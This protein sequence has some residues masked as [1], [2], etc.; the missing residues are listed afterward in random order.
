MSEHEHFSAPE[1]HEHLDEEVVVLLKPEAIEFEDRLIAF[2]TEH[3]IEVEGRRAQEF[4]EETIRKFYPHRPEYIEQ[5]KEHFSQGPVVA[6]LVKG[7]NAMRT[8]LRLKKHVRG[9]FKLQP[10][11]DALHSSDSASEAVREKRAL[12]FEERGDSSS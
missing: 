12:G 11:A 8:C 3:D 9:M 7:P 5:M 10:P 2:L 6:L 1:L 4:T